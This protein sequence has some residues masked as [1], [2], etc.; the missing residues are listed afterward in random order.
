M[1]ID[2]V[3]EE[4]D[5]FL[6]CLFVSCFEPPSLVLLSIIN[7]FWKLS[8]S[9]VLIRYRLTTIVIFLSCDKV[10]VNRKAASFLTWNLRLIS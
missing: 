10:K 4:M 8:P 2:H 3:I 7:L 5:I 6:V 9:V 1:I